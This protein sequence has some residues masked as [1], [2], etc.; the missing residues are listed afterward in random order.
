M[1][2]KNA[3]SLRAL[4][5]V[6]LEAVSGGQEHLRLRHSDTD[7][8]GRN[9]IACFSSYRNARL[10]R[11]SRG[12]RLS[13]V[14]V[15]ED[16]RLMAFNPTADEQH[17]LQ[18]MN[19]FRT[20]PRGEFSR[21]ISTASPIK[22]RDSVIQPDLDF[23]NV[24]GNTLRTELN[25]LSPTHPLTWNE[26]IS[27]YTVGHNQ[28]IIDRGVHFHS[29]TTERRETLI[30]N[31]VDFRIVQGEKINSEIVFGYAK[32][33][34]HLYAS[35]VI[36][37]RRGGPGGMVDG[38]GHRVAIHNPDFEQVGTDVRNYTGSTGNPPLGSKVNTAILANIEN[39]PVYV[40][41]AIFEDKNS[42]G[43]YEAGEGLRNVSFVF[44]DQD[45]KEYRTN[46]LTAGGYQIELPAGTYSAVAT[47]GGMKYT[48]RMSNIVVNDVNVW[49][50]WLYDPD[51]IPPDA[52]ESN[53]SRGAASQLSGED[54]SFSGLNIHGSSDSDYFR[55]RSNGTG[56]GT[57]SIQFT[58]SGG[59][60]DLQLLSA[61]GSVLATSNSTTNNESISYSLAKD[62]TY[63]AR[64]YG[65]QGARNGSYRFSVD[66][67][68]ALP[69]VANSDRA[70][71]SGLDSSVVI[72]ALANDS[73]PDG[74]HA[75]LTPV[76][77]SNGSGAFEV[78]SNKWIRYQPPEGY[79]GVH[80]ATYYLTNENGD[81]SDDASV[82]VFVLDYS[83][84]S[85]WQNNDKVVD[86]NDDS[87][88]SALD[89]LLAVNAINNRGGNPKLPQEPEQ[90]D[91]L[92]G[93]VD[94]S[95]DGFITPLDALMIINW[96]NANGGGEGESAIASSNGDSGMAAAEASV[97]AI[98]FGSLGDEL[99]LGVWKDDEDEGR[100]QLA[101]DGLHGSPLL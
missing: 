94:A 58:H 2:S 19:R 67:P 91:S 23:A 15:L 61:S 81:R 21:L 22:A 52:L 20:D 77:K 4:V 37:W 97:A 46:G 13:R 35:Y 38:R 40:T 54:Q 84:P 49:Q 7:T 95:G 65:Y 34:N 93:F 43:W 57:F 29:N 74:N 92:F 33:V 32:S 86:V 89:A 24:N 64:V 27:N 100:Q 55:L 80:R 26:A 60:L 68:Q 16:R 48:Q 59:N 72:N 76:L 101:W 18:L 98:D 71:F 36:D 78:T 62:A 85:P 9:G 56:T 3:R 75:T 83:D 51:V 50:N 96:I 47:G 1:Q 30:A 8:S 88:V 44:T 70:A 45:G 73:D 99:G 6:A 28:K 87:I 11:P 31:G 25:R 12:P 10:S 79:S 69:P 39:P 41:G 82:A 53:N 66:A 42:T 17:F 90:L 63:Y 5:S 14:E